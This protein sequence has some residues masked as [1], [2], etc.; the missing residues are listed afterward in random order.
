[1]IHQRTYLL[2]RGCGVTRGGDNG[3]Q[4]LLLQREE[5]TTPLIAREMVVELE[6]ILMD[7]FFFLFAGRR[8]LHLPFRW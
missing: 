1:M 2:V 6:Q 5:E 8:S 3:E 7:A 4:L